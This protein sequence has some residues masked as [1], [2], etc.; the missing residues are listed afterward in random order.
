MTLLAFNPETARTP[1]RLSADRLHLGY[2]DRKIVHNLSVT[3]P[4][5]K[6]SPSPSR[7]LLTMAMASM[8]MCMAQLF[9]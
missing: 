6:S 5:Q 8:V 9:V 1:T 2:R 3:I 4:P 7:R